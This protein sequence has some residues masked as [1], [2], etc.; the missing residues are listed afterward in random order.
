VHSLDV[1][2]YYIKCTV[3]NTLRTKICLL[4]IKIMTDKM[5]KIYKTYS[6]S[7]QIYIFEGIRMYV[8]KKGDIFKQSGLIR[9]FGRF[10]KKKSLL[11]IL[12]R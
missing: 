4:N 12:N 10:C 6:G 1:I 7:R 8:W 5:Y 11:S 3:I 9:R 2:H